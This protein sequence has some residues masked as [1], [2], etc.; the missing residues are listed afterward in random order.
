[1]CSGSPPKRCAS[2][3]RNGCSP[4][5]GPCRQAASG[6]RREHVVH[7]ALERLGRKAL[8][9]RHAGGDGNQVRIGRRAH[10]V[11][12]RR[13]VGLE[14]RRRDLAAPRERRAGGVGPRRDE[15]AAADV[16]AHQAARFELAVGADH[17]RPADLQRR[18]EI[19]LR[20]QPVTG[21]QGAAGDAAF[22]QGD[23]AAVERPRSRG[24]DRASDAQRAK[25]AIHRLVRLPKRRP[26]A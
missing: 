3:A 4:S 18:G 5:V 16:A 13:L 23:D 20:R 15:G 6:L 22:E 7:R 1:M 9:R 10:Q 25:Q 2:A 12:H 17:R 26:W 8:E 21:R 14:R 11:A 24:S 19:A